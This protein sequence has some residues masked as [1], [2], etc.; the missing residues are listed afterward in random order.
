MASRESNHLL[1][2]QVHYGHGVLHCKDSQECPSNQ[3]DGP[4][5]QD[6]YLQSQIVSGPT[7]Q[8]HL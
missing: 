5:L 4:E 6:I 2:H 3:L 7:S 1:A 8:H